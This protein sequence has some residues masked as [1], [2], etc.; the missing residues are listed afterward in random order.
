MTSC[1]PTTRTELPEEL[2][3]CAP[4]AVQ[5]LGLLGIEK[6]DSIGTLVHLRRGQISWRVMGPAG[7]ERSRMV[8]NPVKPLPQ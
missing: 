2:E 1:W 6:G 7:I 4:H 8:T 3:R 5:L